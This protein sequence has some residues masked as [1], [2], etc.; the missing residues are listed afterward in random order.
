MYMLPKVYAA[1]VASQGKPLLWGAKVNCY[2]LY[3][4]GPLVD[5]ICG[6]QR[7]LATYLTSAI[8]SSTTSYWLCKGPSVGA[9]GAIFGLV[10]SFAV[11]VLRH[12]GVVK[13]AE[14]DIQYIALIILL[15]MPIGLLS[16][17]IDNWG[18]L[19]GFIGG[20]GISLLLGPV[21]KLEYISKGKRV[22]KDK[23]P[24]FT[25]INKNRIIK[26]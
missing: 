23:A 4:I 11:F 17:G 25:V 3:Y 16:K 1:Q 5:N 14:Q 7:Y 9:S 13:G 15:N 20:V 10:G 2:S 24:I 6:P 22:Y 12:R 8:A 18:H 19:G 21:W 26:S